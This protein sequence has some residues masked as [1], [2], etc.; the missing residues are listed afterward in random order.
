VPLR[1]VAGASD[2]VPLVLGAV[3]LWLMVALPATFLLKRW[4]LLSHA[5]WRR[6]HYAG[7]A[8]WAVALAHG[9]ATGSD[10]RSPAAVALYGV[11][12]G[13]VAAMAAWRLSARRAARGRVR[14]GAAA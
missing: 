3:A 4:K 13:L 11:L 12:A 14:A 8:T 7:Y 6:L 1:A 2:R 5:V 10:T 9:V